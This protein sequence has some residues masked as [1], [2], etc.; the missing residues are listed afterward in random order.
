MHVGHWNMYWRALDDTDGR[1]AIVEAV[2]SAAGVAPFDFFSAVE[3]SGN[4]VEGSFPTW[5]EESHTLGTTGELSYITGK[6]G[7][8]TIALFYRASSWTKVYGATG[9]FESGRPYA[10]GLFEPSSA[11]ASAGGKAVWVLSVHFPHYPQTQLDGQAVADALAAHGEAAGASVQGAPLLLMG[12]FNE[13]GECTLPPEGKC[14]HDW[15]APTKALI[16]PLWKYLGYGDISDAVPY[17]VAT[18]C[19]KWSDAE[20]QTE[21]A[22]QAD[23]WHD[24]DRLYFSSRF[25]SASAPAFIEYTYPGVGSCNDPACTGN[26]TPQATSSQGSWHRGWQATFTFTDAQELV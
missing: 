20:K 23:W 4:S 26:A 9:E 1:H 2:D 8:E 21:Q 18:C 13:F 25:L 15:Y 22:W 11:C 7:H 19:T 17:G 14:P 16:D 3:A 6:S 24:F 10:I 12:D 5:L